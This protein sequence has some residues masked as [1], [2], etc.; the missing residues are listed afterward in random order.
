M[1]QKWTQVPFCSF[2]PLVPLQDLRT[3]SLKLAEPVQEVGQVQGVDQE[4]EV[5][6]GRALAQV[7]GQVQVVVLEQD[8]GQVQVQAQDQVLAPAQ[9]PAQEVERVPLLVVVALLYFR[10]ARFVK[11]SPLLRVQLTTASPSMGI[12]LCAVSKDCG[13]ERRQALLALMQT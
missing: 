6:V 7:R 1:R 10:V 11:Q 3:L 5:G 4:V 12:S 13:V 2:L 8:Q 9:A